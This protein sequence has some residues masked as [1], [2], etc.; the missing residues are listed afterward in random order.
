[1]ILNVCAAELA[2]VLLQLAPSILDVRPCLALLAF[3][4]TFRF[5]V[6]SLLACLQG[7]S[8][9]VVNSRVSRI[10]LQHLGFITQAK[11]SYHTQDTSNVSWEAVSK[12][13]RVC[14]VADMCFNTWS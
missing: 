6:L 10:L 4:T 12:F 11:E 5:S 7:Q 3:V 8:L 1:M 13:A 9:S 2:S 14:F